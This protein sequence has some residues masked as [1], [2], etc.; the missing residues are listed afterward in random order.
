MKT[1]LHTLFVLIG[2]GVCFSVAVLA[3]GSRDPITILGNN[4]FTAE[5]GVVAGSGTAKD[6]Y[7]I[8]GWEIDVAGGSRYGVKVENTTAHFILRGL[9]LRGATDPAGAAIHLGFVT[10]ATIE[11]T[12]ITNSINGIEIASSTNVALNNNVLVVSGQGLRVVGDSVDEYRHQIDTTNLVNDY[13]INYFYDKDGE[14]FSGIRSN[15]LYVVASRNV[16][17]ADNEIVNGDGIQLAFVENSQITNNRVYRESPVLTQHGIS[18]TRCN[19]NTIANNELKNNS[20][21]G[22]LLW[23]SSENVIVRN[24]L[25]ANDSGVILMASDN[26]LVNDNVVFA[27]PTGI[28]ISAGST[29]NEVMRNII[30]HEKTKYGIAVEE[31]ASNRLERNAILECETGIF[32]GPQGNNNYVLYNTIVG[33]DYALSI[34]GSYNQIGQNLIAQ[35]NR[36]ILFPETYGRQKVRGNA[37]HD[38][39]F[40]DNSHHI[41]LNLDSEGNRLY[42]NAFF[43]ETRLNVSD[44]GNNNIWSVS[45]EGN[46]WEDYEGN[47]A[48]G[49]GI[50]DDPV[51]VHPVGAEDSAPF[52]SAGIARGGLGVLATLDETLLSLLLKNGEEVQI[53]VL[54]ADEDIERFVGFRGFPV[55][56]LADFP[57]I[58]FDYGEEVTGGLAGTAFTMRTV[59]FPLDIAFF[60]GSGAFVGSEMM[61]ANS[62]ERYTVDGQFRFALE[63]ASGTLAERGIG[64]GTRLLLPEK[65]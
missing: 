65:D 27:N 58:L 51:R 17:I 9:I 25:L 61:E 38:N 13:S 43:G 22:I 37:L 24:S 64:A 33:G 53:P 31:A 6:P 49:D 7:V 36:G 55:F 42:R 19:G 34:T 20:M 12:T 21:A 1:T 59:S 23:L 11:G 35:T 48:D 47:D 10:A 50:G 5:N 44:H 60:D 16:T 29:G 40:A 14:V 39:V 41:Y 2:V 15:N 57:G 54:I 30:T 8:A 3:S 56:L 4:D 46:F 63:L 26:N 62:E 52:I 45:G 32:L 28:G 18:L